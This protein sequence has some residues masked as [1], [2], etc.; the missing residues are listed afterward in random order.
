MFNVSG[1]EVIIILVLAL[2]VLGPEKLP[3]VLRKAGKV[4]G[5]L[6]RLTTG[7]QE[8]FEETFKEPL[9][10]FR[11]TANQARDMVN[12]PLA[13]FKE[14]EVIETSE[15]STD[16]NVD[17]DALP[18]ASGSEPPYAPIVTA[19]PSATDEPDTA[20]MPPPVADAV[21]PTPAAAAV[22]APPVAVPLPPPAVPLWTPP[23]GQERLDPWAVDKAA[24]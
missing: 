15:T 12:N 20:F 3:E 18:V 11:E 13:G 19:D 6:R 4:Y 5:D 23:V 24:D 1:G 9:R 17:A 2:V 7:F 21:L 10:E 8:E 16:A 22:L 14:D